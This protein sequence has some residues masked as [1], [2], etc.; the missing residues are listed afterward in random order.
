MVPP[1]QP[2]HDR[3]PIVQDC[4]LWMPRGNLDALGGAALCCLWRFVGRERTGLQVPWRN[5]LTSLYLHFL[6]D[7][8]DSIKV[9]S[10]KS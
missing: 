10:G 8:I 6:G 2:N 7:G 4:N 9:S 3:S 1:V 5:H